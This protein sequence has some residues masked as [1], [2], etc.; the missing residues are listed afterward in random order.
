M[1]FRQFKKRL[2]I[3]DDEQMV[4][5]LAALAQTHRLKAFRALVVAGPDGITPGL[6]SERLGVSPAG[7][8]FHLKEL[9]QAGLVT[10]TRDG[11]SQIYRAEFERMNAVLHFLSANCC[12]GQP[13]ELEP[14]SCQL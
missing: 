6:L 3:M 4:R 2:N 12:Q 5:A 14:N 9:V 8:S 1:I 7:M 13:C 10:Q 11:R